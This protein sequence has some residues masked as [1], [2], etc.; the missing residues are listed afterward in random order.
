MERRGAISTHP[1]G[2]ETAPS[3]QLPTSVFSFQE[4]ASFFLSIMSTTNADQQANSLGIPAAQ[5]LVSSLS[6][7]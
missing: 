6:Y 4:G 7:S 3:S 5:F 1:P 2:E